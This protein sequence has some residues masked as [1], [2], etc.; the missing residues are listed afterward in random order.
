MERDTRSLFSINVSPPEQTEQPTQKVYNMSFSPGSGNWGLTHTPE[1]IAASRAAAVA[2]LTKEELDRIQY[3]RSHR[4]ATIRVSSQSWAV[5]I[6]G[7]EYHPR[8]H[9]RFGWV[10]TVP[11]AR[12]NAKIAGKEL[13]LGDGDWI[14]PAYEEV[15]EVV[16]NY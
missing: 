16:G 6:D 9:P 13:D 12:M 15:H 14:R 2:P 4:F 1:S 7:I 5:K 10:A 3:D 8:A 11:I